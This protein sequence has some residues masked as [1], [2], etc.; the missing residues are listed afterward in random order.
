MKKATTSFLF[1]ILFGS[2]PSMFA[3]TPGSEPSIDIEKFVQ[4]TLEKFPEIPG[5][6]VVVIKDD[7]PAFLKAYGM[8]DKEARVNADIDTMWYIASSTKSFTALAAALVDNDGKI[9]LDDAVTKYTAGIALKNP[10]PEKVKIRDLLTHTSGLRNGALG[11]RMAYSGDSDPKDM[12]K[13]FA[14]ATTFNEEAYGRYAYTNLGY[15]IY[16]V[17]L[18]NHAK[19][20]WQDLLQN[21]VFDPLGMNHTTSYISRAEARKWRV[22]APYILDPETGKT[23]RSPL[24]KTDSNL[25]SAGGMFASANDLGKWLI[26]NMNEGRL[27]GKQI[28]PAEVMKAVHTGY[29]ATEREQ[30]PFSGAGEYGLGWQIGRYKDNRV[31]YHHG[32]FPGYR[33]HISYLPDQKIGVAVLVNEGSIGGRVADLLAT[34][35]Y[36]RIVLGETVEAE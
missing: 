28:F 24:A 1:F 12:V 27:G 22:A 34:Y 19:M 23:V 15:N 18:Q 30:P 36:D 4:R 3:Q 9:R 20:R 2:L 6:A 16:A 33:S 25:Q 35:A 14:E 32:G 10:I 26:V 7:K 21:R 8:A 5:I 31:I 11:F 13:V 29:T 17:L